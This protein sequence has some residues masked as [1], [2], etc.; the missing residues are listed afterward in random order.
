MAFIATHAEDR[1]DAE[2]E[3]RRLGRVRDVLSAVNAAVLR[4]V[5]P[6]ML[7]QEAC[8]VA[9]EVAGFSVAV[10]RTFD[11]VNG[12]VD[13]KTAAATMTATASSGARDPA[14]PSGF[15]EETM[16]R[17]LPA[18]VNDVAGNAS[19]GSFPFAV[20]DTVGALFLATPETD[21]FTRDE[22]ELLSEL[23]HNLAFALGAAFKRKQ[24]DYLSS[25]DALTGLPNRALFLVRLQQM[26][27]AAGE[28]GSRM[29]LAVLDVAQLSSINAAHGERTGDEVLRT[30]AARL[31]RYPGS[32]LVA[33]IAGN[34]FAVLVSDLSVQSEG[35]L[36]TGRTALRVVGEP[37]HIGGRDIGVK[38][39][40]GGAFFPDDACEAGE[41]LND[42]QTAL[43][44]ARH[45]GVSSRFFAPSLKGAV[46]KRLDLEGRLREAAARGRF[47]LVYQPKV[48]VETRSLVGV[49]ALMRWRD[50]ERPGCLVS[51]AEFIPMLE[52]TGMIRE[53]G[54]W[55]LHEAARQHRAWR[56][57]G[58]AAPRIAVNIAAAQLREPDFV[59]DLRSLLARMPGEPG[60]EIEVTESGFLDDVAGAVA[61][62][63]AVRDL[64]IEIALDDFGARCSSLSYLFQ[65]P[66]TTL[67]IDRSFV[68]GVADSADK[69]SIVSTIVTLSKELRLK[70]VAEGVETEPQARLLRL[71]RCDQM[72]GFLISK[73]LAPAELAA[74]FLPRPHSA[75]AR[76]LV[77]QL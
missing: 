65:L 41:L 56:D 58:L 9:T 48:D 12:I 11:P 43:H 30:L 7:F 63:K 50:P 51:A 31:V 71:L 33:R 70:V 34:R 32:A 61:I 15:I 29:L 27:D 23:T 72:Q 69:L 68:E 5:E 75:S 4:A 25:Y 37:V 26:L 39:H 42:A 35:E 21:F 24:V 8:R 52:E 19:I 16:R 55:A 49:E 2:A 74:L 6:E 18:V 46:S 47:E 1:G 13:I 40:A 36:R 38:A 45:E 20:G 64:G 28:H 59:S 66:V 3:I 67:K 17:Q 44:S 14:P 54:R 53:I 76:G 60:I 22:I 10:V 62:L 57:A 77:K 73:P